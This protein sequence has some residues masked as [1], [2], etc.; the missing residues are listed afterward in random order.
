MLAGVVHVLVWAHRMWGLCRGRLL[1]V[2]GAKGGKAGGAAAGRLDSLARP[3]LAP[4]PSFRGPTHG[5]PTPLS[6]PGRASGRESSLQN[7][8]KRTPAESQ[9]QAKKKRGKGCRQNRAG[10]FRLPKAF[11]LF[12]ILLFVVHCKCKNHMRRFFLK[13]NVIIFHTVSLQNMTMFLK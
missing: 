3:I 4:R 10:N 13:S 9:K 6:S 5:W 1:A 7:K 11:V 2:P 8:L 12:S